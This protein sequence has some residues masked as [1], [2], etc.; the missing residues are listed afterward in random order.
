MTTVETERP[1][2]DPRPAAEVTG[3]GV[4]I[5]GWRCEVC[6]YPITQLTLRCPLCR[7]TMRETIFEP[8]GEVFAS[9]CLR[10]RVPGYKPPFAVAYLTLDDGPRVLTHTAGDVP[11]C[12]GTR[13]MV[14]SVS[15]EGDLVAEPSATPDQTEQRRR[16]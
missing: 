16:R 13:A 15:D 12:P 1:P 6:R 7:G 4:A 2:V 9:T 5:A 14:T 8:R 11:L 3:A 10:V